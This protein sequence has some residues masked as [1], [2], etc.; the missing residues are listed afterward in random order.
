MA[1]YTMPLSIA[2]INKEF[3]S[4]AMEKPFINYRLLIVNN[5][6][7]V[8]KNDE[9]ITRVPNEAAGIDVIRKDVWDS[10]D[11]ETVNYFLHDEMIDLLGCEIHSRE[12]FKWIYDRLPDEIIR[13]GL[14]NGFGR[15]S[16]ISCEVHKF[17]IKNTDVLD[18]VKL[19]GKNITSQ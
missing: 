17:F 13:Y 18:R 19:S 5:W 10:L 16:E 2:R 9:L 4:Q 11:D 12:T 8:Y 14:Q 15:G 3:T 6:V 1:I 7:A